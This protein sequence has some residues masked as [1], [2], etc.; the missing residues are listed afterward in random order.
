MIKVRYL[1]KFSYD[2]SNFNGYQRQ[3]GKRCVEEYIINAVKQI[4]NGVESKVTSS[5]RT[6]AK[7]HALCQ[8][9][10]FT[11]DVNITEYKLKCALN[12]LIPDDIHVFEALEVDEEF[13][14][15]YMVKEKTY[16][17]II[18][19]GEYEPTKRN[20]ELQF[21]R[22]LDVEKMKKAIKLFEGEHDFKNFVSDEAVKENYVRK[23]F[24]TDIVQKDNKLYIRFTGNGFM[25]YQ[26]RNMVGTLI[27][28]GLNKLDIDIIDKIFSD[29]S[30]KKYVYTAKP[31]GLYL[32]SII[33]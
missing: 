18:N 10:S 28:I 11:L 14:P 32:E 5:S 26:V 13:H 12:S 20:Y 4:N 27:K 8:E 2:G 33:N 23:I 22:E 30:Y 25:K 6:D 21:G 24:S 31:E 16:L 15:R 9:A 17:Y 7:V 3:P 29:E 19:M 1:I